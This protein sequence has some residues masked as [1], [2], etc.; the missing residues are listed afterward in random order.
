M[1]KE[2][3][4][5]SRKDEYGWMSNFERSP[6]F[7]EWKWYKTNEHYYQSIK[8][9]DKHIA[10][11]IA[12]APNPYLAMKAGRSLRPEEFSDNWEDIKVDVMLNGLRAKFK[13]PTLREKL[14]NTGDAILHE[15]SATDMF[16]G[17]KGQDMLGK[18]LMKVREEIRNEKE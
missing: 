18:L 15:D 17:V 14:L 16:W 9:V 7:V 3:Y 4:F 12:D 2:I 6:Q 1:T 10:K 13:N 8:A 11:W 5:Y